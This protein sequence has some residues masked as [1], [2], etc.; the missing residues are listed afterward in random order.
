MAGE[1]KSVILPL[2]LIGFLIFLEFGVLFDRINKKSR[3]QGQDE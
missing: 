1:N 3:R 2:S